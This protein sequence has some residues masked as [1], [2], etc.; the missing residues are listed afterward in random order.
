MSEQLTLIN[1]PK[2]TSSLSDFL[3]RICP[4]LGKEQD[5]TAS[6]VDSFSRLCESL[7]LPSPTFLSLRM[8]KDSSQ[9]TNLGSGLLCRKLPTLGFMSANGNCLILGGF[10][11]KIESGYTLSDILEGEV[12]QK[13]F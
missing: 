5:L 11:P 8:S 3:A 6:E 2:S 1:S 4:L 12:D 13:Y 9:R 10:Y 7:G